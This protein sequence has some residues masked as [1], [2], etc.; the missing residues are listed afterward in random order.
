MSDAA[1][2]KLR[3]VVH[4]KTAS[5]KHRSD[6]V[7][8]TAG[9]DGGQID[10]WRRA[11]TPVYMRAVSP[12]KSAQIKFEFYDRRGRFASGESRYLQ[13]KTNK[14]ELYYEFAVQQFQIFQDERV[15]GYNMAIAVF[16]A[17]CVFLY[18][19]L[20]TKGMS[21]KPFKKPHYFVGQRLA[22]WYAPN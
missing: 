11:G 9:N 13:W 10:K 2:K 19:F 8:R 17:R 22:P 21:N 1:K 16:F 5:S 7:D 14:R 4:N 20:L 15:H 6:K 12:K 18:T 3:R